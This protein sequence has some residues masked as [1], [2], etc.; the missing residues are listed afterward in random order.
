MSRYIKGIYC[1]ALPNSYH[2]SWMQEC[3]SVCLENDGIPEEDLL[4][5]DIDTDLELTTTQTGID[6]VSKILNCISNVHCNRVSVQTSFE[7]GSRWVLKLNY[8]SWLVVL[9][10][11]K[12]NERVWY[13]KLIPEDVIRRWIP[14]LLDTS[15]QQAMN[16]LHYWFDELEYI[17]WLIS[18][19]NV[20]AS[21]YKYL[22]CR[23]TRIWA[24]V[25]NIYLLT[26]CTLDR[27][28]MISGLMVK[29]SKFEVFGNHSAL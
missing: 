25:D 14:T 7:T 20:I 4:G 17:Y 2:I 5:W 23:Y 11:G 28:L 22:I 19:W 29:P 18:Y 24:N 21:S 10:F 12:D 1:T 27:S 9:V 26:V 3:K 16:V 6:D 8:S 13:V 15:S